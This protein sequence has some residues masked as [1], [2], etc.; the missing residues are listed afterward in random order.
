MRQTGNSIFII[1]FYLAASRD[2]F[3]SILPIGMVELSSTSRTEFYFILNERNIEHCSR[4]SQTATPQ[5]RDLLVIN[6]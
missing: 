2:T 3:I 4:L 1:R 5:H 6:A